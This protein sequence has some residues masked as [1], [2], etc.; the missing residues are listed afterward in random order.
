M[1]DIKYLSWSEYDAAVD[2][3][4]ERFKDERIEAIYGIPRGGLIPAVMLS[5]LFDVPLISDL[6][7][8]IN[9]P[10]TLV[11]DDIV[12]TGE[13]IR[14]FKENNYPTASVFINSDRCVLEPMF[15]ARS[16]TRWIVFPYETDTEDETS[17]VKFRTA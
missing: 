2:E 7:L 17:K 6:L 15:Y 13:T 1:S 12:D 11:V 9:N 16:T 5:H 10:R 14:Y 3:I 4:Y 8:V